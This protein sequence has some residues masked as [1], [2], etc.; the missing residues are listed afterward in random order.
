[1]TWSREE[2]DPGN[3][4][5][6]RMST[7]VSPEPCNFYC[8]PF[9]LFLQH[10]FFPAFLHPWWNTVPL[11]MKPSKMYTSFLAFDAKDSDIPL[12]FNGPFPEVTIWPKLGQV[13]EVW[14]C[15]IINTPFHCL[16][17]GSLRNKKR[18]RRWRTKR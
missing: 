10:G 3:G 1:M 13:A 18:V 16:S 4:K 17:Y 7:S 9:F 2:R 5:L 15:S 12:S 6:P 8:C 14:S 11:Q